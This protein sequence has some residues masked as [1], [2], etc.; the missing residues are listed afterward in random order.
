GAD[1]NRMSG[2]KRTAFFQAVQRDNSIAI[3]ELSLDHGAD[4]ARGSDERSAA[5]LAA[6]RGRK[7]V[8]E[9]FAKRA[10]QVEFVG[11]DRLIA[12]CARNDS[13]SV[14]AMAAAEPQLVRDL[15]AEGGQLVA[16]FAGN[17]NAGGVGQLLDLGVD[18][19]ARHRE[20]DPYFGVAKNSTALH[21][22]A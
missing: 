10:I 21:A 13:Q 7:D 5:A 6:R 14:R 19:N 12:A 4:P 22:A 1:E 2:W 8:L 16:E 17:G 3:I 15:I 11:V 18:V 9:L 20:G